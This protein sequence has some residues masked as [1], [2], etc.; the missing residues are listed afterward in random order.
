[1][2][3]TR[4][5]MNP[6]RPTINYSGMDYP[7]RRP[8]M[9]NQNRSFE[10]PTWVLPVVFLGG[11]IAFMIYHFVCWKNTISI[12]KNYWNLVEF[13]LNHNNKTHICMYIPKRV[14]TLSL[15]HGFMT[16]SLTFFISILLAKESSNFICFSNFF[17]LSEKRLSW[18]ALVPWKHIFMGTIVDYFCV[19]NVS[20]YKLFQ[21]LPAYRKS[22]QTK[23]Y[24]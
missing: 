6:T 3:Q 19:W 14:E 17:S 24:I 1:M 2:V 18:S 9:E 10:I 11:L 15:I 20:N 22:R 7:G 21:F 5:Q 13:F 12:K 8:R 4:N 23:S 16:S